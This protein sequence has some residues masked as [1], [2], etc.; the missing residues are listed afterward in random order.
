[1]LNRRSNLFFGFILSS[2]LVNCSVSRESTY[3]DYQKY[4]SNDSVLKIEI[5]VYGANLS[6]N[7]SFKIDVTIT[8]NSSN[9]IYLETKKPNLSYSTGPNRCSLIFEIGS[10]VESG[11][12]F[13]VELQRLSPSE[14]F[15]Y[16]KIINHKLLLEMED[17]FRKTQKKD[18]NF[19][20]FSIRLEMV[21]IEHFE[22]IMKFKSLTTLN[23]NIQDTDKFT[24]SS[25]I[26][27]A[28]AKKRKFEGISINI[29]K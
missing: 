1:M 18:P 25:I 5:T 7:D 19:K 21:F 11:L 14:T 16:T 28:A 22:D 17:F 13:P 26:F 24:I 9:A 6:L 20:S 3:N 23:Q 27:D 12:E 4:I 10:A 2:L 29:K 8:N 15:T